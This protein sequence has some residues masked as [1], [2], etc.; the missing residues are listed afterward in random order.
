MT[1][2]RFVAETAGWAGHLVRDG[3]A[4]AADLRAGKLAG[5]PTV[6]VTAGERGP[7]S[8]V[9]R[10]HEQLVAWIPG[11]EL[12]VWEGTT[13]PLHIQRPNRVAEEVLALLERQLG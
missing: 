9:R 11:A 1:D 4:L 5:T 13:H 12:Q 3:D 10:G 2:P 8:A 7:K 6:V